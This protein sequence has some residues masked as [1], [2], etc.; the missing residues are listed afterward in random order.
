MGSTSW[1]ACATNPCL[2]SQTHSP[3]LLSYFNGEIATFLGFVHS[4]GVGPGVVAVL[5]P[6]RFPVLPGLRGGLPLWN[7]GPR[8]EPVCPV[9]RH[10]PGARGV[11]RLGG[12]RFGLA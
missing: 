9:G 10:F 11:L 8:L 4:S 6:G 7:P 12:L 1:K 5:V 3:N 2:P